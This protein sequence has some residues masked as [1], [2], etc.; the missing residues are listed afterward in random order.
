MLPR[1]VAGFRRSRATTWQGFCGW[2]LMS[3]KVLEI[4]WFS[5]MD[6]HSCVFITECLPANSAESGNVSQLTVGISGLE[7][8]RGRK[9]GS[10]P[11]PSPTLGVS[12]HNPKE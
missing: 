12:V 11:Q 6:L 5:D 9:G 3:F 2:G 7:I 4:G 8:W 10:L 1:N